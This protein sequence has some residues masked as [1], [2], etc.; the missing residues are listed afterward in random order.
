MEPICFW[1]ISRERRPLLKDYQVQVSNGFQ[2]LSKAKQIFTGTVEGTSSPNTCLPAKFKLP[3]PTAVAFESFNNS[4][5]QF[6]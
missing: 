1:N 4:H 2:V 6:L 5:M 3:S